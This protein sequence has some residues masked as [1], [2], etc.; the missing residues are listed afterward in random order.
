MNFIGLD[1]GSVSVKL[2]VLDEKRDRLFH[3]Y[4]RH[5]GHPIS[6]AIEMLRDVSHSIIPQPSGSSLSITGS[7]GRLIASIL[8]L[9]PVNE[10]IAQSYATSRLFPHINTI[11]E[12]GGEDSKLILLDK[13]S[14]SIK[15]FSMNSKHRTT[16]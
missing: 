11:I 12:M 5:K 4:K 7:S 2:V 10:I 15:D 13:V 6:V 9:E 8:R 1:A 14:R 16:D 3:C